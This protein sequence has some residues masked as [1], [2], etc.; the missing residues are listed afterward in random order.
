MSMITTT[1]DDEEV[2]IDADGFRC[3]RGCGGRRERM[4]PD[5]FTGKDT[6]IRCLCKC[7]IERAET[8]QREA[9][10][11][12]I[13]RIRRNSLPPALQGYKF[14]NAESSKAIEV[15]RAYVRNWDRARADGVGLLLWG[16]TGTGKT[17][18]AATVCNALIDRKIPILYT[19]ATQLVSDLLSK[20]ISVK[21]LTRPQLLLLDDL[22]AESGDLAQ[23]LLVAAVDARIESGRPMVITTNVSLESMKNPSNPHMARMYDRILQRC[24]PVRVTGESRRKAD[25]AKLMERWGKILTVERPG[26]AH[27]ER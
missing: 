1:L 13:E 19:K 21:D 18:A 7:Q 17:H 9:E 10:Q 27:N 16:P 4:F 12:E 5:P 3:C 25:A 15:A 20:N 23:S 14:E 2:Y 24:V 8:E 11:C 22:G 26:E 6:K